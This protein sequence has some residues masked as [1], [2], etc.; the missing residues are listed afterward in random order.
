VDQ[1]AADAD[2]EDSDP[3]EDDAPC[4]DVGD[5]EP[6]LGSAGSTALSWSYSQIG[7]AQGADDDREEE[8]DFEWSVGPWE[9]EFDGSEYL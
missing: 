7:W 4:E 8:P 3:P 2:V 5:N 1:I 6:S 9:L